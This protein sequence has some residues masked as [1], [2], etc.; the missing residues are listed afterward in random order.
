MII[1]E[2]DRL[3]LRQFEAAVLQALTSIFGEPEVMA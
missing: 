1:F 3:I 2:T